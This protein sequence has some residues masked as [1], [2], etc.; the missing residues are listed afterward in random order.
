M[1]LLSTWT[2]FLPSMTEEWQRTI[3]DGK[4]ETC[5]K[6]STVTDSYTTDLVQQEEVELKPPQHSVQTDWFSSGL[7]M[8]TAADSDI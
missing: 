8:I 2:V 6:W 5:P 7:T 3:M 1:R 4:K